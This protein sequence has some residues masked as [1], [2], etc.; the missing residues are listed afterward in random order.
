MI[1]LRP[2]SPARFATPWGHVN[3][4]DPFTHH[5]RVATAVNEHSPQQPSCLAIILFFQTLQNAAPIM[6]EKDPPQKQGANLTPALAGPP[7]KS[8]IRNHAIV[9]HTSALRGAKIG[10]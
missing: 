7:Q 2:P 1:L 4:R 3:A 6:S 5:A 8:L 9:E 10:A